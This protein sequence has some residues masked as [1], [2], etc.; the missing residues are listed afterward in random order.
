MIIHTYKLK[1][2]HTQTHTSFAPQESV[3]QTGLI[4]EKEKFIE[5]D[6]L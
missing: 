1:H 4:D 5:F 2:I 3:R 6:R